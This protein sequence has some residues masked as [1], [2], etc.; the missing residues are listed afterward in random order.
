KVHRPVGASRF[1]RALRQYRGSRGSLSGR[2]LDFLTGS[3]RQLGTMLGSGIPLAE[4]VRAMIEQ[5]DD[6]R[7]ETI[8]RELRERINSGGSLADALEEHPNLFSDLYVGMVRAA[9]ATGNVDV[10]LTRLADSLQY[11]RTLR[12]KV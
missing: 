9:E 3:T 4:A 8:F 11:Q 10:V 7:S 6:R 12:R 1:K 5:A 2:D